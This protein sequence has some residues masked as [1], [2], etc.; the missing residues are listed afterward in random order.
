[1]FFHLFLATRFPSACL[2]ATYFITEWHPMIRARQP[3]GLNYWS[4]LTA[5]YPK[6][7]RT[8]YDEGWASRSFCKNLVEKLT[9]VVFKSKPFRVEPKLVHRTLFANVKCLLMLATFQMCAEF[10]GDEIRTYNCW[11]LGQLPYHVCHNHCKTL[12]HLLLHCLSL[13]L[14]FARLAPETG[15]RQ[16]VVAHGSHVATC[17]GTAS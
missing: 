9:S 7:G 11:I 15:S 16:N 4:I 2:W 1:M 6:Q 13:P 12:T 17:W 10:E 5:A 8:Q 14:T 3:S